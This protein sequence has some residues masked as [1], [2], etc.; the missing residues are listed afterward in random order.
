MK[1][2]SHIFL[3]TISTFLLALFIITS[4]T[5]AFGRPGGGHSYSGGG[6]SSSS[7]SYNSNSS[8]DYSTASSGEIST[9]GM[10]LLAIFGVLSVCSVIYEIVGKAKKRN[11]LVA[12]PTI[13]FK[14]KNSKIKEQK[15][16]DLYKIDPNFSRV[17]FI[18]FVSSLYVKYKSFMHNSKNLKT[19]SPFFNKNIITKVNDTQTTIN[20]IVIG[21]ISILKIEEKK[22]TI[23]I[24]LEINSNYTETINYKSTRHIVTERWLFAR[25][26]KAVSPAP[27]KM[28]KLACPAC[29]AA[30]NFNDAGKCEYCDNEVVAGAQQWMVL[31][32]VITSHDTVNTNA[33]LSYGQEA[34]TK[35][36][37]IL[38]HSLTQDQQNFAKT[39]N[40]VWEEYWN[41]FS[42]NISSKYFMEIYKN[43]SDLTWENARHLLTDRQWE[44][45]NFWIKEYKLHGL[46][47]KLDD[48]KITK[49]EPVKIEMDKFYEAITVRI[50]ASSKDYV[51]DKQGKVKA[52]NSNWSRIFSEY[53]TFVR[54]KGVENDSY[55]MKTCPNCGAPAD[56]INQGGQC[57]YCSTKI[58]NGDF[59]WVLSF[60]TQDEEYIG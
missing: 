12:K 33:L 59:S 54:R 17:L 5:P 55:D 51:V 25:D 4:T 9:F 1:R 40:V 21:G 8:S 20:E 30:A 35:D 37:T 18:D 31:N 28:Q 60:I 14:G 38:S 27:E 56:K 49:I 34:G 7:S 57:E 2:N 58:S 26:K 39:H 48:T 19:I 15:I 46:Q 50:F 41:N 13:S 32:K 10:V 6:S 3:V 24:L 53:W 29:G 45:F 16:T 47:N 22:D 36:A 44:A 42:E 43:W 52:G 23:N 11:L